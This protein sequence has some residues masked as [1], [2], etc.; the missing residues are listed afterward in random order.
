MTVVWFL[1][2]YKQSHIRHYNKS[3]LY[4]IVVS[5]KI[6]LFNQFIYFSGYKRNVT[7]LMFPQIALKA[8]SKQVQY[9]DLFVNYTLENWKTGD[10]VNHPL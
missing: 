9:L 6:V 8:H 2:T 1:F 4:I 7:H 5:L 10:F 3:I